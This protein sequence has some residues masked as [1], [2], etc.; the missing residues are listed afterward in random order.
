MTEQQR[1]FVNGINRGVQKIA[2]LIDDLIGSGQDRDRCRH[3][4]GRVPHGRDHR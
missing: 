1:V 3:D 2:N 4:T